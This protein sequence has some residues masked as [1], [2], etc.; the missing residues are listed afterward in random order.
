MDSGQD[1]LD[2]ILVCSALPKII[3]ACYARFKC[4][5]PWSLRCLISNTDCVF[6][7]LPVD[8]VAA[9]AR[10][11]FSKTSSLKT[12][13]ILDSLIIRIIIIHATITASCAHSGF[14]GQ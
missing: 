1:L 12:P 2:V 9:A 10:A 3:F 5:Q 7:S 6:A 13:I 8:L 11:S 4:Q 14:F